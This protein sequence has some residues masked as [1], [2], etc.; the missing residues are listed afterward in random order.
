MVE[1]IVTTSKAAGVMAISSTGTTKQRIPFRQED[2]PEPK[3]SI[4][5]MTQTHSLTLYGDGEVLRSHCSI[6]SSTGSR[7]KVLYLHANV[8]FM[9]MFQK[10]D[11]KFFLYDH[12][13]GWNESNPDT[14]KY[15]SRDFQDICRENPGRKVSLGGGGHRTC[16]LGK[17]VEII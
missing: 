6:A 10:H 9:A 12:P 17:K 4:S 13:F 3:Y 16:S 1:A 7:A 5:E 11:K 15:I 2:L 8:K 14:L